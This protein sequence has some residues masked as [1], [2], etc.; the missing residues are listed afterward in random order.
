MSESPARAALHF[1]LPEAAHELRLALE[2]PRLASA[3]HDIAADMRGHLKHSG[4]RS[5][6]QLAESVRAAALEA[7]SFVDE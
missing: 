4:G 5:A 6:D 2:A 3:L 7:L 1:D